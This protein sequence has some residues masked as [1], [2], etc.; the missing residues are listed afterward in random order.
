MSILVEKKVGSRWQRFYGRTVPAKPDGSF[1]K[2][3][4][5][6]HEGLYRATALFGGDGANGPA[7]SKTYHVR[8]PRPPKKSPP[9]GY[10]D[11]K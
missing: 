9:P 4:R 3:V 5:F 7:R 11:P 10:S 6:R 2:K 8:V 1:L